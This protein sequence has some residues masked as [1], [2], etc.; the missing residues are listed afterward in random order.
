MNLHIESR[1][2]RRTQGADRPQQ[3]QV[4]ITSEAIS[5]LVIYSAYKYVVELHGSIPPRREG[6]RS[7]SG[8][9]SIPV[10]HSSFNTT[11]SKTNTKF[12]NWMAVLFERWN[13]QKGTKTS[14]WK[15]IFGP[16]SQWNMRAGSFDKKTSWNYSVTETTVT[17]NG[18]PV[19]FSVTIESLCLETNCWGLNVNRGDFWPSFQSSQQQRKERPVGWNSFWKFL[20]FPVEW[21]GQVEWVAGGDET[22]N[23]QLFRPPVAIRRA[24]DSARRETTVKYSPC[25]DGCGDDDCDD[26]CEDCDDFL[27]FF[28]RY[29]TEMTCRKM[30]SC[31][32]N[33]IM[34]VQITRPT[35][36]QIRNQSNC[37]VKLFIISPVRKGLRVLNPKWGN[38]LIFF[39]FSTATRCYFQ[40]HKLSLIVQKVC[41]SS[42]TIDT[43]NKNAWSHQPRS[44][45][46]VVG[47]ERMD[48]VLCSSQA[49]LI[50]WWSH[51]QPSPSEFWLARFKVK[52]QSMSLK[53]M[54]SR[55]SQIWSC[56]EEGTR[57]M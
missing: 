53:S 48:Q 56:F 25:D 31:T 39:T 50:Y 20:F 16:I 4:T 43:R 45:V 30:N 22:T 52:S 21:N 33:L 14:D 40:W 2:R 35:E 6:V 29:H 28:C 12:A 3:G 18:Y 32:I 24:H 57:K 5:S 54:F 23:A 13:G 15:Q 7:N 17:L 36:T 11:A 1:L 49:C 27:H 41:L 9:G 19:H 44:P 10:S 47:R 8:G 55:C 26:F 37:P 42:M 51:T 34:L 38:T 46:C